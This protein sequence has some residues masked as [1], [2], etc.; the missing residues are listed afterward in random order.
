MYLTTTLGMNRFM[1]PMHIC[2][3]GKA[4]G[5]HSILV[6]GIPLDLLLPD[7]AGP[8]TFCLSLF[9]SLATTADNALVNLI[10]TSYLQDF[11]KALSEFT[12][13]SEN[14]A[15]ILGKS[16]RNKPIDTTVNFYASVIRLYTANTCLITTAIW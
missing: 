3:G 8:A 16:G 2:F 4:R 10:I 5:L 13:K 14:V 7:F 15:S 6:F 9:A 1:R 11:G 12:L